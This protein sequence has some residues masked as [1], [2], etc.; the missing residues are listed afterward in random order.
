MNE[1][2]R[3]EIWQAISRQQKQ[4][5]KLIRSIDKVADTMNN[6]CKILDQFKDALLIA[7]QIINGQ[8]KEQKGG[9]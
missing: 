8:W 7:Q 2:E 5:E 4:T 9:G 6:V 3:L 1:D